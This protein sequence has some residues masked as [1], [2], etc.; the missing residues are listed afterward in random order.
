MRAHPID[1]ETPILLF[2]QAAAVGE[3]D[4]ACDSGSV[5]FE[6]AEQAA[7]QE[8]DCA[9]DGGVASPAAQNAAG[10]LVQCADVHWEQLPGGFRLG[11]ADRSGTGPAVLNE[12]AWRAWNGFQQPGVAADEVSQRLLKA[13]LLQTVGGEPQA[14]VHSASALTIWLH[15]TNACSLECPYCYVRKSNQTM[16]LETGESAIR[17]ACEYAR[18]AGLRAIKIKYAGGEATL[19]FDR[20]RALH[21]AALRTAA[22]Y[23]LDVRGVVLSN[24]VT[25]RAEDVQWMAE[26]QVGMM[27]S[28]DG[29]GADHDHLRHLPG[30]QGSFARIEKNVDGLLLAHGMTPMIS[31]TLTGRNA[32]TAAG[33]VRWALQRKL[34]V[35]V[36][37][38]RQ[39][40]G[41]QEDASL[42]LDESQVIAGMQAVYAVFEEYLPERPF[43]NG[44]LDRVR[45]G[46]H[47]KTCGVGDS[48]WVINWDGTQAPC[49][50][51][52]GGRNIPQVQNLSIEAKAD[53]Q[54]CAYAFYCTG[55]CPLEGFRVSGR[56]DARSPNC[57]IYRALLPAALRLEGLR[58]L[59]QHQLL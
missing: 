13:G 11:L 53:C 55:G 22:E 47:S 45:F 7:L 42:A 12:A 35:S 36:N 1:R 50:M 18:R 24:G 39:P 25:L 21:A 58:L 56:W 30:G 49:H 26:N 59:K 29:A 3:D 41:E 6:D 10:R 23:G 8:N 44:L 31:V 38:Y 14:Q 34:P 46:A 48:Y 37:F 57:A 51:L 52:L 5:Y 28:L 16:T 19:H 9:C 4:C 20:I 54:A 33:A 43:L 27:I 15:V 2:A 17:R 32:L 40:L